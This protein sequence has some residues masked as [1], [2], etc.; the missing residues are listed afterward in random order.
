MGAVAF[1]A[2]QKDVY[3]S[4][5]AGGNG[6]G[7]AVGLDKIIHETLDHAKANAGF[8]GSTQQ[9]RYRGGPVMTN[10][11]KMYYI[12]YGDWTGST[13]HG[14]LGNLAMT[15]GGSPYFNINST[16]ANGGGVKTS[17][18]VTLKAESTMGYNYGKS[19]T[20]AQI[21]SIVADSL[22]GLGGP[23]PNGVY[24]VL[25]SADVTA[26]SGF[27]TQYCGWHT[28]ALIS[29]VDIKYSFVGNADRCPSSCSMQTTSPNGNSGADAM[30]S[31]IAH[32]LEEAATDPDLNA[33]YDQRG[34]ENADKCAWTF[35]TQQTAS[36]GSKYNVT[37]G[38]YNYL[39]QQNWVN[40]SSGY[41]AMSY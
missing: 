41:C 19:L 21:R 32:E 28:H 8:G 7:E 22:P 40:T 18:A 5:N 9:M 24:F 27:C 33:W 25:T 36:N 23:D 29:G 13:A 26:S 14:I 1:G 4:N 2:D 10:A 37:L 38:A 20:D 16:Y 30:A 6:N 17:T 34:Y 31:I 39:I 35:G 15:I 12:W 11:I 3:N